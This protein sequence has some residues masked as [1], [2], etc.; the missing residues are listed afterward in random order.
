MKASAFATALLDAALPAPA[1]LS[2]WNGS[3]PAQ[4]F[5][6]YRNNVMVSLVDALADTFPVTLALVGTDFFRAMAREFVRGAPP[7]SPVLAYYGEKFPDF[8][9]KFPPAAAVPCLPDVARLEY[10]RVLAF[11]A[12]DRP[13]IDESGL[14]ALLADPERLPEIRLHLVPAVR[15]LRSPWAIVSLWGAHQGIG[16]LARIHPATA[17]A[18]LVLRRGL[19]VEIVSLPPGEAAF[20]GALLEG[21]TLGD[22][23]RCG[24]G[25]AAFDLAGILGLLLAAEAIA[26]ITV[27]A[28]D[29][30]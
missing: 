20:V 13:G 10:A 4:R 1:G 6:V 18:A 30:P 3:D 23:A 12:A 28:G 2:T 5:A 19:D 8:V 9:E 15:L 25:E 21:E 14:H 7:D 26:G 29:E 24:A 16:D 27:A 11:H 17:E 22:A